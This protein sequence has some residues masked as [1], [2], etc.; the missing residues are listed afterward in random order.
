[1][2]K[3]RRARRPATATAAKSTPSASG[4]TSQPW[5][6]PLA[7][8]DLDEQGRALLGALTST[9][10]DLRSAEAK[11]DAAVKR[12]REAGVSW[13]AIGLAL[14]M[15]GEGARRRWSK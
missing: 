1:M 7:Y 14:G 12:A 2:A 9:T 10:V 8:A 6:V 11:R 3:S 15:T 5:P 4:V 13:A